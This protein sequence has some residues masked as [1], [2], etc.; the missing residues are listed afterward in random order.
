MKVLVYMSGGFDAHGPSNHLFLALMEDILQAGHSVHL[1]ERHTSGVY[2][3]VPET[4]KASPRFS[5]DVVKS[6]V[7]EKSAFAKRYLTLVQYAFKSI[8]HLRKQTNVDVVFVQSC[9]TAPFQVAFAK[10]FTRKPVI[11]NIQDMFPGSSIASGVMRRKWMQYVFF[12]FSENRLSN[13]RSYF[14]HFR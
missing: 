9:A 12:S 11:Y 5:Y 14:R 10:V 7:V 8:R 3:D 13:C 2:S 1:I 6:K 4:L